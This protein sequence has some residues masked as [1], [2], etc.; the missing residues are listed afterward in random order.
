MFLRAKT[1]VKTRRQ[2]E[3]SGFILFF[4]NTLTS[5]VAFQVTMR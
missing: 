5:L 1:Q 3:I 2:A 4:P